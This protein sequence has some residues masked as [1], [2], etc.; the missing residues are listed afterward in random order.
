[1]ERGRPHCPS[2]GP[3]SCRSST[4][5]APASCSG[6]RRHPRYDLPLPLSSVLV[7]SFP[8]ASAS[9]SC[10]EAGKLYRELSFPS[11]YHPR[12]PTDRAWSFWNLGCIWL[13]RRPHPV[14]P[15]FVRLQPRKQAKKPN[16]LQFWK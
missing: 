6:P 7:P 5:E 15:R 9:D 11:T 8:P 1:M 2:R 14:R 3:R 4:K 12:P 10:A 13:P 16:T